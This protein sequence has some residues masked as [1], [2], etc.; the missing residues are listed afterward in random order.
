MTSTRFTRTLL[1]ATAA[2]LSMTAMASSIH[3]AKPEA[4]EGGGHWM[5]KHL[6]TDGDG[7]ISVQEFQAAGDQAFAR[8]DADGDGRISAE[9]FAAARGWHG[10][11]H[12]KGAHGKHGGKPGTEGAARPSEEQ[13]TTHR[14]ERQA[15]M[16]QARAERF[17]RMDT[18]NDGSISRAEF[19]DA[20]MARFNALDADGN[21]VIDASELKAARE[22]P[23]YGKRD[24]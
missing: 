24:R 18:N 15:R 10:R 1:V 3:A 17:A 4:R 19:D 14:A 6:D 8:L 7:A 5:L 23:G 22:R 11:E 13:R 16:E 21:G 9:E 2:A 20:R 12:H